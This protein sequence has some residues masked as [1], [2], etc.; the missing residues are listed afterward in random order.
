[1]ELDLEAKAKLLRLTEFARLHYFGLR[2][3]TSH[4]GVLD[5]QP[6]MRVP[7]NYRPWYFV[8]ITI[9][10]EC[11]FPADAVCVL[12]VVRELFPSL[13]AERVSQMLDA[14]EREGLLVRL[15]DGAARLGWWLPLN[16]ETGAVMEPPGFAD[17]QGPLR[18]A[19]AECL[20]RG[21]PN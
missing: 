2:I 17:L 10:D 1:M 19:F 16:P 12:E 21:R 7:E 14:F 18:A 4:P 20:E 13:S 9:F 8:L 3:F 5:C 11:P 6:L 15:M